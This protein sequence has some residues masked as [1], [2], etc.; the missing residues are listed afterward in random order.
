M[1]KKAG[2]LS[3]EKIGHTFI[4][5]LNREN[6]VSNEKFQE[7]KSEENIYQEDELAQQAT[8]NIMISDKISF[9]TSEIANNNIV[10]TKDMSSLKTDLTISRRIKR[11]DPSDPDN[12][13]EI[14]YNAL[15]GN[16]S[17]KISPHFDNVDYEI[18]NEEQK[19]IYACECAMKKIASDI[20]AE[21]IYDSRVLDLLDKNTFPIKM[22][23]RIKRKR[24]IKT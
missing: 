1:M 2:I 20:G 3:A 13:V 8:D 19:I 21:D 5:S 14:Y 10:I 4:Y 9:D 17:K 11:I 7:K 16:Y 18:F 12:P 15:D 24:E 22:L 6:F 23:L